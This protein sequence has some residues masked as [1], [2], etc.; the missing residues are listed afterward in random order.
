MLIGSNEEDVA[1][2]LGIAAETVALYVAAVLPQELG[3]SDQNSSQAFDGSRK[4]PWIRGAPRRASWPGS[5]RKDDSRKTY[6][7]SDTGSP[8]CDPPDRVV[9]TAI[10]QSEIGV[11]F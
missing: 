10:A 8:A 11:V 9:A 6:E 5:P 2:R 7:D 1:Q 3:H 4:I